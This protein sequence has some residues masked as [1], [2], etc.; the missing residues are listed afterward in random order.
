[1][2]DTDVVHHDGR[3]LTGELQ[4]VGTAEATTRTGH[5]NYSSFANT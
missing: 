1:L 3:A 5:H 2:S 4:R